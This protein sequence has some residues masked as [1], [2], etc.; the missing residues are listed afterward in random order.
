MIYYAKII[1]KKKPNRYGF[2]NAGNIDFRTKKIP[3]GKV[4]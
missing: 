3:R 2:I 4:I 1:L